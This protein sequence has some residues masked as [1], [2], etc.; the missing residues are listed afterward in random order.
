MK[1]V[2][3]GSFGN[4]SRLTLGGGG[5][6]ELWG[7][8]NRA[9]S[10][11]TVKLALDRGITLLDTAP[12]YRHC[13]LVIA[14]AFEGKLPSGVRVTTKCQLGSPAPSEIGQRLTQSLEASLKAMRFS[15]VDLFFLHSN[16]CEDNYVYAFRPERQDMFATRWGLYA[17]RVIPTMERLKVQ[18]KIGAWGITGTG[19]PKTIMKALNHGTKPAAVQAIA[20]LLFRAGRAA[21]HHQDSGR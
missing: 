17:E 19:V 21:R 15:H 12:M 18:G 1:T 8:T 6:G 7:E 5:I 2:K 9:E 14:E 16:I 13:E 4:V 11:A 3:L 10:I 20:N